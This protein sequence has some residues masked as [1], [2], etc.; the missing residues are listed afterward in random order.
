MRDHGGDL[1][2]ARAT[3]GA[4]RWLDLSTGINPVPYLVPDVATDVWAR[5][6]EASALRHV[7]HVAANAF[8]T[9]AEVVALAGAQGAIQLIPR[10][11][12]PGRATV[13]GPTY[14]E[15]AAALRA[16]GW[17]VDEVPDLDATASADLTVV[18][19]PNNPD[20]RHWTRSALLALKARTGRLVVDESF[21]DPTPEMSVADAADETLIVLRSFGKFFGLAGLRLG[22][23]LTGASTATSLRALSGPWA[24]S[25][26]ALA[27]G[28]QA[29]ADT[30][31]QR[32]TRQRLSRDA[33][34]LDA[35]AI[36]HSW[37]L[38]GG[39]PLFRTYD[40]G[41]A[42][43]AQ[44]MLAK[45]HIWSRIFPYSKTWIRLGLPGTEADWDH[46]ESAL[47]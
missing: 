37:T 6:P 35:M 40:T 36:H 38:V 33:A 15:H 31:W 24:V 12:P 43:Q 41:D 7:E 2:R 3:Y 32:E 20:G 26:P 22:F 9:D 30:T 10:L 25:G 11:G 1:D 14:N 5:L 17:R 16:Q 19:N 45:R 23:A 28:A 39:T 29:L 8:G 21:A 42:P 46:L 47:S 13:V 44:I 27:I 18:V 34:R 4:G